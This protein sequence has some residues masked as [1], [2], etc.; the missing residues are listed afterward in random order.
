MNSEIVIAADRLGPPNCGNGGYVCGT[1]AREMTGPVTVMLRAPAPLETPLRLSAEDG[2]VRLAAV[3]GTTI[4]VA[5]PASRGALDLAPPPPP[6]FEAARIAGLGFPGL[7]RDFHGNCFCCRRGPPGS[8]VQ[9]FVGQ[10]PDRPTGEVAGA[11]TPHA[12]F[13]DE[14]GLIRAEIVWTAL[15]CPGAV[16]WVVTEGGQG[17]VLG[18]VTCEILRRP[19]LGEACII[20]AWRIGA[21]RRKRFSG[22]ALHSAA[23]DVLAVS[24]QVWIFAGEATR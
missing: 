17:G 15:D 21:E 7:H 14:S 1:I 11:W 12:S 19:A 3:D 10:L 13:A 6:A 8:G 5:T 9:A 23:G 2:G 16:A 18:S 20:A 22:V 24:R 4:A